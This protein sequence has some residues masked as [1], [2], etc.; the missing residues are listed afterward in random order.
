MGNTDIINAFQL[1][2]VINVYDE[3]G[4]GRIQAKP[5]TDAYKSNDEVSWAFPLLPKFLNIKPKVGEMVL[6]FTL[7][8]GESTSQRFYIGPVISQP[9]QMYHDPYNNQADRFFHGAYLS[10]DTPVENLPEAAGALPEDEDIAIEGRKNCGL[11][12]TDDDIRLRAGVK[13]LVKDGDERGILFNRTDSAFIK[14]NY[15]E[16]KPTNNRSTAYIV[17]DNI[18]L[19]GNKSGGRA[20]TFKTDNNS[21]YTH[22]QTVNKNGSKD[23]KSKSYPASARE[24]VTDKELDKILDENENIAFRLPYGDILIEFLKQFRDAF[25]NHVHPFPTMIPCNTDEIKHVKD[26]DLDSI[27]SD[28]VRIN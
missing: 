12:I 16:K 15:N 17:A 25:I 4:G 13:K 22:L 20:K 5:I 6:L 26:F 3:D 24:L 19:L 11:Q 2:E 1:C 28:S 23:I 21:V 10:T 8:V 14:L 18:C 27:L 9:Q 7:E